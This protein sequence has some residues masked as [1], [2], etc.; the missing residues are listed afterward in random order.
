MLRDR[1]N[2]GK[3]IGRTRWISL[4]VSACLVVMALATALLRSAAA[5]EKEA[6]PAA[7]A[8]EAIK[9]TETARLPSTSAA[10]SDGKIPATTQELFR[11]E[12]F[13]PSM[14][15]PGS[16][17][18]FVIRLGELLRHP[19]LQPHVDAMNTSMTTLV[20]ELIKGLE[21]AVDL[22]DIEWI[23]GDLIVTVRGP[24][25]KRETQ[26]RL[27]MGSGGMVIRI[28]RPGVSVEAM[29]NAVEGSTIK[30]FEGKRYVQFP[31]LPAVGPVPVRMRFPDDRTIVMLLGTKE[32]QRQIDAEEKL[33]K[34]LFDDTPT[35]HAW[36][37]EWKA[38]DGGLITLVF[39]NSKA[40][41]LE[42][43]KENQKYPPVVVPLF[44]KTQVVAVGLDW[45]EKSNR[46]GVRVRATCAEQADVKEVHLAAMTAIAYWPVF[47]LEGGE[48]LAKFHKRVLQLF[49]TLKVTPSA[50]GGDSHYLDAAADVGWDPQEV[51]EILRS[52]WN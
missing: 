33:L 28:S 8:A 47:L 19:E 18:A 6:K 21:G 3:E 39:D 24:E 37:N 30:E 50:A 22:R 43:P 25:G 1:N 27:M 46:T 34:R 23:A 14:I 4:G 2:G 42:L 51:V 38:V 44:E 5:D 13:D 17:G 12:A 16:H 41:W 20:H 29:A 40:G 7:G 9:P 52:W 45:T 36:A 26:S 31:M 32:D 35:T 48:P 15:R 11:R 10:T 49:S